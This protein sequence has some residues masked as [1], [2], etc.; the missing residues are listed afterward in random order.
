MGEIRAKVYSFRSSDLHVIENQ[1]IYECWANSEEGRWVLEK[2]L[3][4]LEVKEENIRYAFDQGGN[5]PIGSTINVYAVF[6]EKNYLLYK[7]KWAK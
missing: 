4:D 6:D 7:L 1:Q 3:H 5:Y 2:S